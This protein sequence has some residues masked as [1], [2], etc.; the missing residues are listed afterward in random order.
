MIASTEQHMPQ[1]ALEGYR[2]SVFVFEH[3]V[4]RGGSMKYCSHATGDSW[5]RVNLAVDDSSFLF[6]ALAG[7]PP[8]VADVVDL[9]AAILAADRLSPQKLDAKMRRIQLTVPV[10]EPERLGSCSA[11]LSALLSWASAT[12][13]EF[14]FVPRRAPLRLAEAVML[15]ADLTPPDAEVVL[16]SGG[17][18]AL[19][20]VY[21]LL[22]AASAPPV[23]LLGSGSND[24]VFGRQRTL[25]RELEDTFRGRVYLHQVPIRMHGIQ[26]LRQDR[27]MRSRGVIFT[28]VGCMTAYVLG[29]R[30]LVLHEN[31]VGALNLP[32]HESSIGLD[33]VRSVHPFTLQRVSSFVSTI[34]GDRF[35]VENPS[36]LLTKAQMC[37]PLASDGR[38]DLVPDTESCDSY[39]R[40]TVGHCGYCSSC[41]L[42]RQALAAAGLVDRTPY[43]VSSS[44]PPR[45][46]PSVPLRAMLSQVDRLR[47]AVGIDVPSDAVRWER[48]TASYPVLDDVVDRQLDREG[49][50]H[51]KLRKGL[52]H[53]YVRY[54][55]EWERV[56]DPIAAGI[57]DWQAPDGPSGNAT[58][59]ID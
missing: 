15:L 51:S 14:K 28:L 52:I 9:A 10:R 1:D 44:N 38:E 45:R 18:D 17:L 16:W 5:R 11:E 13:W 39:H 35:D 22:R 4:G 48:L 26:E 6:R 20:G 7:L 30:R 25:A 50:T 37:A 31:G 2:D 24:R 46:D 41:L 55:N 27:L 36:F 57:L 29:Q 8:L 23:V 43:V 3:A 21:G 53:M 47:M 32:Y 40:K 19:A 58:S 56:R 33:H 42:R 12:E 49:W 34:I 54:V 59:S